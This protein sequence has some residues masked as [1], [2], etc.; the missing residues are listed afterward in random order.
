MTDPR[1]P[2]LETL[3]VRLCNEPVPAGTDGLP[4]PEGDPQALAAALRPDG[5]WADIN[6][7]DGALKDWAAAPHLTRLRALA[8]AWYQPDSPHSRQA[9]LLRAVLQGLEGWY[10]RNPQ[11]PNWWWNEIGA[12]LLLGDTLLFIKGACDAAFVTRAI[13]AFLC[14]RPFERFT[15]QNL[16]W[17]ATVSINHGILTDDPERVTQGFI[18]IGRE[19]RVLP[20]EEGIQ[21]DMSFHQHGKLLYSGGYGQCF[22]GDVGRLM[23]VAADTPY[24]FPP[25]LVDLF[26]R[27]VLDGSRWM[28]RG[29]TF[30]PVAIGRE[31]SRQGHHAG[32]FHEGLRHLAAFD[33]PRRAE[34][35]AS[36]AVDPAAGRSLVVGNRYFWNSD[37][38]VQ[39]RPAY[40]LSVRVPSPRVWN[41]DM[42]CCGG[43]GRVCHHIA[44]GV[45]M[46]LRDGDEYRD[47]FPV[48]NWRQIPGTT[49]VQTPA[50]LD[51]Q[52]LRIK[53][54]RPFAG[55][56]SD[57]TVGCT[58]ADFSRAGLTARKAWFL[59]DREWVALGAGISCQDPA[60]V[61]TTI[62]QCHWRGP[63]ILA[64][65]T[66]PL[67]AGLH[68]LAAGATLWHDGVAYKVLDGDA[69]L[70]LGLQT[71][72]WSDCGVGSSTPLALPVLN[73]GL[74]HGTGPSNA[75]YA[76]AVRP[77]V[78]SAETSAGETDPLV[79]VRN[80][81]ALQ[82][83]WQAQERRGQAVFYEPG[84]V[85]FP[86]GQ[87]IAV[88]RPCVFLYQ[89]AGD[90]RLVF[91]LAQPEQ[92][93][94]LITLRLHGT[95][96]G[97]L[98]ASLPVGPYAGSSLTLV[99][100]ERMRVLS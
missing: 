43:E 85:T 57:G 97:T 59:F 22:A 46:I 63:A 88:D 27:F 10:A 32:R 5:T 49:A 82:A 89:P 76:Y 18:L 83:V 12:P 52:G 87:G 42:A 21:P 80:E 48:W 24:A 19:L 30:D 40:S 58:A 71:G 31:I 61:R 79:I 13:P 35:G 77:G 68:R 69:S 98:G 92:R 64:G 93:E 51:P 8:R 70:R 54:E 72:A 100:S 95:R 81:P 74:D 84:D 17:T 2:A 29:R 55:G 16:V 7:T 44:D 90:G 67:A 75:T 23:A 73:L 6:Y 45:T 34:A 36:A 38:M 15:G 28:V 47:L 20:D 91:T 65:S 25:A 66:T 53:G 33:H 9:P 4:F 78:E 56:A 60:P 50:A 26:A 11:N 39:H 96:C 14:H 3:R 86:D 37:L 62:N 1:L 41:A 94:G 99:W